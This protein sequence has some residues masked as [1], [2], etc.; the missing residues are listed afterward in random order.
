MLPY[1]QSGHLVSA[2][3]VALAEDAI[4][5]DWSLQPAE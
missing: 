4:K 1:L 2:L 3:L 5:F